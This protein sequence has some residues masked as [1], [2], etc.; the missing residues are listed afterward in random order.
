MN[1]FKTYRL[2]VKEVNRET[3][4][5]ITIIFDNSQENIQYISGQFLTLNLTID[6]NKVKRSYSISSSIYTEKDIHICVKAVADGLV[7]NYLNTHTKTGD[8]IEIDE[9][10]GHVKFVPST[11]ARHIL[12]FAAGSG[13]TPVISIIK[14]I[15]TKEP[16]SKVDLFYGCRNRDEIIYSKVLDGYLAAHHDRFTVDYVLSQPDK[17]WVGLD[18]RI[19]EKLAVHFVKRKAALHAKDCEYFVC[20]PSGMMDQVMKALDLL[21]IPKDRVFKENFHLQEEKEIPEEKASIINGKSKVKVI[22]GKKTYDFEVSA[23]ETILSVA[24]KLG[25]GLPYSC[26]AGMCTACMGKCT[27]GKVR[28][29]EADGLT[30]NEIKQGY[31]LTCVGHPD[32]PEVVIE[33]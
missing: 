16:Q 10:M 22:D 32:S 20:G 13:I 7:S 21:E 27:S 33:L 5:A 9:P 23:N 24:Q 15:L 28:M 2:T 18:G 31:V 1:P 11:K 17:Y 30:D 6:G 3:A 29:T 19:N 14:T 8:V 4:K 26:Q 12:L 25:Y